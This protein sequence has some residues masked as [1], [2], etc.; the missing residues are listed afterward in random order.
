MRPSAADLTGGNARVDSPREPRGRAV[1]GRDEDLVIPTLPRTYVDHLVAPRRVGDLREPH[2]AGEVGS[3]VGG[4]GVRLTLS[5]RS[6]GRGRAVI[7]ETAAR[8]FGS[9]ALVAPASLLAD[10]VVGM[11]PEE[12]SQVSAVQVSQSLADGGSNGAVL[13]P[14]VT[15]SAEFVVEALHRA[16]GSSSGGGPSDPTG[17]GILVCRC[18][19][20]GD[21]RIREAV[22]AGARDPEALGEACRASTGCRSCRPDLLVLIDEETRPPDPP[23]PGDLHPVARI[24]LAHARPHLRALGV[25]LLEVRVDGDV[26]R[27]RLG[28]PDPRPSISPIGALAVT[29]HLLRETVWDHI[30]VELEPGGA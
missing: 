17:A 3:M 8:A 30:R 15:K 19:G 10:R 4:Q 5:F 16:L 13:P 24:A 12:A 7:A 25:P 9:A 1:P 11:S 28:T 18:L 20:V 22:R 27:L 29:R 6:S 14:R 2:A 26:V 21:R 23:P